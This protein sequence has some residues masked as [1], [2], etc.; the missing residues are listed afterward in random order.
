MTDETTTDEN[1]S[2]ETRLAHRCEV[3]STLWTF[4][5]DT[6]DEAWA[7][8]FTWADVGLPLSYMLHQELATATVEGTGVIDETW[9][10]FCEMISIDPAA[11]YPTLKDAFEASPNAPLDEDD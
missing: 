10:A 2:D 5:R 4:Y 9:N 1:V 7:E 6:E 8:F 11:D 3:L